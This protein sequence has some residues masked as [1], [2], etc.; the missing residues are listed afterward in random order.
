M[1]KLFTKHISS[2][3]QS[4][5]D[6]TFRKMKN[7]AGQVLQTKPIPRNPNTPTQAARRQAYSRLCYLWSA[8]KIKDKDCYI[9]IA[10]K[11][12]LDKT[13]YYLSCYLNMC[14]I[15]PATC[16]GFSGYYSDKLI[17]FSPNK[18]T[19]SLS[20]TTWET[21]ENGKN[22]LSFN[23]TSS[24]G[25]IQDTE[26]LD[27]TKEITVLG[28]VKAET[29]NV[30][31][32]IITKANLAPDVAWGLGNYASTNKIMW[33]IYDGTTWHI[34]TGGKI[35]IGKWKMVA[36]T[37]NGNVMKLYCN[38]ELCATLSTTITINAAQGVP[39]WIGCQNGDRGYWAGEIGMVAI[40]R[41]ALTDEQIKQIYKTTKHLFEY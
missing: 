21:L 13:N 10:K 1:V 29:I 8:N 35:E 20:E 14:G 16:F 41:K 32:H 2:I 34:L 23:G 26:I 39:T 36:G 25:V 15:N 28:W 7:K 27:I 17:D 24:Y 19:A 18:L 12:R 5:K 37:Y 22:V 31:G 38:G 11:M 9:N 30:Y 6:L 40:L 3:S 33:A 4:V